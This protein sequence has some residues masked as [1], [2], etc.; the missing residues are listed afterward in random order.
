M[1]KGLHKTASVDH[2]KENIRITNRNNLRFFFFPCKSSQFPC[3]YQKNCI[4]K[5]I[6]RDDIN[7]KEAFFSILIKGYKIVLERMAAI[8]NSKGNI[9][10]CNYDCF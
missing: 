9:T 1:G 4:L 8:S 2:V 5:N 7:L 6:S 10:L 3:G